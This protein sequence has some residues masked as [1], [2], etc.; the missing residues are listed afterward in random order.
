MKTKQFYLFL[1][2]IVSLMV[3]WSCEKEEDPYIRFVDGSQPNMTIKW[4][5]TSIERAFETNV[6]LSEIRVKSDQEW[7]KP[8]LEQTEQGY[9]LKV[10]VEENILLDDREATVS[11]L[12]SNSPT[13][14]T[15]SI[16]QERIR[17]I[18]DYWGN[19]RSYVEYDF[20][21]ID[22]QLNKVAR[23]ESGEE[24]EIEYTLTNTKYSYNLTSSFWTSEFD[25]SVQ[26]NTGRTYYSFDSYG[27]I[28]YSIGGKTFGVFGGGTSCAMRPNAPMQGK[29]I[30]RNFTQNATSVWVTIYCEISDLKMRRTLEFVNVPIE[31]GRTTYNIVK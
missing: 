12:L 5:D 19:G 4:N 24:L 8:T 20:P 22:F 14:T 10:R 26:D 21:G 31:P 3:V 11:F 27:S 28:Y 1:A 13:E 7:C 2:G 25:P 15:F 23:S 16:K 17:I 6:D 18:Y 29:I 9:K 30:V